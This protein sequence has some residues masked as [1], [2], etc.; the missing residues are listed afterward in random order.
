MKTPL[1][2]RSAFSL[3]EMLMVIAIIGII[4]SF[5]IPAATKMI[6]GTDANRAS[7]LV[8]DQLTTAR[9]MAI[10]RNK[11]IEVRFLR[12]ADP[13]SPG[14]SVTSQS[15]WKIRGIQLMEVTGSGMPVQVAPMQRLPASMM[16]NEGR[17]SSLFDGANSTGVTPLSFRN[18]V[19]LDPA[20]PRLP[21]EKARKYSFASFRYYPD[22][23]TSLSRNGNW[24]F[25]LHPVD[26]VGVLSG[27]PGESEPI[28]GI[29]Y[30]T[31]QID[32][33]TGATRSYRPQIGS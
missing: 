19:D 7:Q 10:A 21:K 17:Y 29:N 16:V 24:Y 27:A 30:F 18:P 32:P 3:I 20:M 2:L 25:T 33:V 22:G 28:K 4:S 11:Q 12:F 31:L 5:A 23:S 13:E 6:R 14:E 8:A 9:Q 1:R 15:T 26:A